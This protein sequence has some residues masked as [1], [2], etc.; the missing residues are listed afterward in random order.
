MTTAVDKAKQLLPRVIIEHVSPEIDGGLFPIKRIVHEVVCVE[1]DIY[2]EGHNSVNAFL[3]YRKCGDTTWTTVSMIAIGNDRW[4]GEL[5]ITH[6]VDYEYSLQAWVND[7]ETWQ[8]DFRKKIDAGQDVTVDILAGIQY[9]EAISGKEKAVKRFDVL[10]GQIR[11]SSSSAETQK[12]L[13]SEEL[14]KL[15][16]E[17]PASSTCVS[18]EKTLKV[19]VEPQKALVS[20]WYEFFPRSFGKNGA[21]GTF[22]DAESILPVIARMGFD[23]VYFPPIHPIGDTNRKGRNNA[24]TGKTGDP[25]SPWAIGNKDGGHKAIHSQLGKMEDFQKLVRTAE[26]LGINIA[27]DLAYQCSPDH[28]YVKEHPE[29][30][31]KRPDGSIQYAENPPKKYEDVYPINFYCENSAELWDELKSVVDFWIDKGVKIFRVDNPH[32]K[33]FA[34]WAWMIREIRKKHRDVIFLAEA[35]TRP[36]IMKQLAKLGFHQSYTYFTWRPMKSDLIEYVNELTRTESREYFRPN[37]WPNTPDILPYHLQSGGRPAFISRFVLAATLSSNYGIY[38][39][40][41]DLCVKDAVVE[42]EEY[43]ESEKYEI[44]K[45]DWDAPGNLKDLMTR[46]N[47]IRKENVALQ[48]TWNVQF[49][50]VNNDQLIAYVKTSPDYKNIIL[51]VVNLDSSNTQSGMIKVPL[52]EWGIPY[53][54]PYKIKDLLTRDEYIWNGDWN[55]VELNPYKIPAHIFCIK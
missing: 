23:V 6:D 46:V 47:K 44:K 26:S 24:R 1:A 9:L 13:L 33:P 19:H 17:I 48:T 21:H 39:P 35:F 3:L 14:L 28:P 51:V 41:F 22:K 7:F 43:F 16:Q 54:K 31:F 37:F 49:C 32:T 42:K 20:S 11:K 52:H 25:G 27:L 12:L 2:T 8:I 36:N 4:Q 29:W 38:G 18:Y 53:D 15:T 50:D 40:A 30:F 5:V 45:W 34:F 10:R 55:F